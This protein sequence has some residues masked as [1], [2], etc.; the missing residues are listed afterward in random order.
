MHETL[1]NHKV[2]VMSSPTP[3]IARKVRPNDPC[4]CGSGKKEKHCHGNE[5]QYYKTQK[6]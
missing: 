5:T 3:I 4:W 6:Q 2:S 1:K